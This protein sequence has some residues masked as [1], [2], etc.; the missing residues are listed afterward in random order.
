MERSEVNCCWV[1]VCG[2]VDVMHGG[3][4]L[5]RFSVPEDQ[6]SLMWSLSAS[7]KE[8]FIHTRADIVGSSFF[9]NERV[10]KFSALSTINFA[11]TL[12]HSK[13]RSHQ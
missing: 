12:S 3:E 1:F 6:I 9:M 2:G 7:P 4:V 10:N 11:R 8:N 5:A 13:R